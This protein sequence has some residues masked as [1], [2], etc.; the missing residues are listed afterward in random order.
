MKKLL[1]TLVATAACGAVSAAAEDFSQYTL[2]A[3]FSAATNTAGEV[4]GSNPGNWTINMSDTPEMLIT[5]NVADTI[6]G[7]GNYLQ[8]NTGSTPLWRTFANV[9]SV[10]DATNGVP[11]ATT[12][13]DG[14]V[15]SS[16]VKLTACTEWPK[17]E[18][19]W[20]EKLALFLYAP[21]DEAA[22]AA[23]SG[24]LYAVGGTWITVDGQQVFT[25]KAY[26]LVVPQAA[27][28]D[29]TE[30][31][32]NN[33]GWAKID[34][35]A[36]TNVLSE[37]SSYSG[38]IV[39]VN[40]NLVTVETD[41]TDYIGL[42]E[43]RTLSNAA[44][45]RFDAKELILAA[46][47]GQFAGLGFQGE[48][49]IDDVDLAAEGINDMKDAETMTVGVT[50]AEFSGIELG[51]NGAYSFTSSDAVTITLTDVANKIVTVNYANAG[52]ATATYNK[53]AGTVTFTPVKDATLTITVQDK[54]FDV[55]GVECGSLSEALAALNAGGTL[56]LLASVDAGAEGV[57]FDA[58]M[59]NITI[60]LNG[61]TLSA[62][63]AGEVIY[64]D[65]ANITII[66]SSDNGSGLQG[67]GK[68][69]GAIGNAGGTLVINAGTFEG[70]IKTNEVGEDANFAG[71][72]TIN[73]GKFAVKVGAAALPT[74]KKWSALSAGY[75]SL[76]DAGPVTSTTVDLSDA[77]TGADVEVTPPIAESVTE[78]T[79]QNVPQGFA[80][81]VVIPS[82]VEKINLGIGQ[83]KVLAKDMTDATKSYD[84]TDALMVD[85]SGNLVLNAEGTVNDVPVKPALADGADETPFVVGE[86]T[87][88]TVKT[89]PGLKYSLVWDSDL[90]FTSDAKGGTDPVQAK[91]D[92]LTLE[93]TTDKPAKRFYKVKVFIK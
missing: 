92:R 82:T 16:K 93:D 2:G 47:T 42:G 58:D 67:S 56:K 39:A 64:N 52:E 74:N 54:L 68:V 84:I 32:T 17:L 13:E 10:D 86:T 24:G 53:S 59:G 81:K 8:I 80:G 1:F 66:D 40:D 91:T 22:A 21:E 48:G 5:N 37:A 35:K 88:A 45:A 77:G 60:D 55:G 23:H 31:I 79:V 26:K 7:N 15:V 12:I 85:G 71:K 4:S 6:T 20:G 30:D 73:G 89:I 78:V 11:Q 43:Q 49:G 61:C 9:T 36:Y 18:S 19:F 57:E 83:L 62:T 46:A 3:E 41:E 69:A 33:F 75:Y 76:V 50:G 34:I 44:K 70:E 28:D 29:T 72:T 87:E 90:S 51:A 38:F 63:G 25:N 27:L 65:G 14:T